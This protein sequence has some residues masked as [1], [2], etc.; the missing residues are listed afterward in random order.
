[1]YL[2]RIYT[3]LALYDNLHCGK[4]VTELTT[5]SKYFL[6]SDLQ[7]VTLSC[8]KSTTLHFIVK[9]YDLLTS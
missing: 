3:L 6:L 5:E 4:K 1:M 2:A 9:I 7:R 8:F